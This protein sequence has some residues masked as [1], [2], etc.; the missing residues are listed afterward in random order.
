MVERM[1]G[2]ISCLMCAIP[3]LIITKYDKNSKEPIGFW[4]GDKTYKTLKSKV[5]NISKYNEEMAGLYGK[6]ASAFLLA[7][8]GC[9]ILPFIGYALICFEC[10]VGIYLVYRSYKKILGRYS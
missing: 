6:C 8:V 3:F 2:F 5:K 9:I 1:V 7:G 4:S 10:T